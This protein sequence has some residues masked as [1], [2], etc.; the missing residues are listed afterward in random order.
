ML[1]VLTLVLLIFYI[2][3]TLEKQLS[4][5]SAIIRFFVSHLFIFAMLLVAQ[6][7]LESLAPAIYYFFIFLPYFLLRILY[8]I[9]RNR[10]LS[11]TGLEKKVITFLPFIGIA[12]LFATFQVTLLA[13]AK[14]LGKVPIMDGSTNLFYFF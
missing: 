13:T 14:I 10:S 9:I 5:A 11:F 1:I 4:L 2:V 12:T 8:Q 3:S 7:D 6:G